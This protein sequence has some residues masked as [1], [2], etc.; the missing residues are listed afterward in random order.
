MF[1]WGNEGCVG[2]FRIVE[3]F[4]KFIIGLKKFRK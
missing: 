1:Y 4:L 3:N 2:M